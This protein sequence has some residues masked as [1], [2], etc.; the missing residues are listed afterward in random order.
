MHLRTIFAQVEKAKND[1]PKPQ[2]PK[3]IGECFMKI[4]NHLSYITKLCELYV[5]G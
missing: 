2:I 5:Q 3:Y 4:A 1:Q